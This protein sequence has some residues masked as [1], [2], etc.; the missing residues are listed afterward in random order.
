MCGYETLPC[1]KLLMLVA[2]YIG[3]CVLVFQELC[4]LG[5]LC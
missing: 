2:L 1:S 5:D 3:L 4:C